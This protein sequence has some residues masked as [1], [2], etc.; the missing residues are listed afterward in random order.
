MN[1]TTHCQAKLCRRAAFAVIGTITKANVI[2]NEAF[3]WNRTWKFWFYFTPVVRSHGLKCNARWKWWIEFQC[4]YRSKSFER[5]KVAVGINTYN[6]LYLS[7]IC[8]L[9]RIML[10]SYQ[11]WNNCCMLTSWSGITNKDCYWRGKHET[12]LAVCF[13]SVRLH[14]DVPNLYKLLA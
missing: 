2:L 1:C 9:A 7:E 14:N 12:K 10:C 13:L 5:L 6:G 11:S 8:L 3:F 4:S